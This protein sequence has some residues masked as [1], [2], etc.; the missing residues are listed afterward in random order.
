MKNVINE[1]VAD[2]EIKILSAIYK[3]E[4]RGMDNIT[5][6]LL[7]GEINLTSYSIGRKCKKLAE[8]GFINREKKNVFIY[9]LKQEVKEILLESGIIDEERIFIS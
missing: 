1:F 7:E 4:I 2:D 9:S 8:D 3:S 5:A 6:N